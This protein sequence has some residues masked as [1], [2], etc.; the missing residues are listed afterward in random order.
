[1]SLQPSQ[2]VLKSD[3]RHS[4]NGRRLTEQG[5]LSK[6]QAKAVSVVGPYPLL[7]RETPIKQ[8]PVPKSTHA[9]LTELVPDY[10]Q[11][12]AAWMKA[13]GKVWQASHSLLWLS[14]GD[15]QRAFPED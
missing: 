9:S 1:M 7:R 10:A 4:K 14:C 8:H 12:M 5:L 11:E 6:Q 3:S 13:H 15:S 2:N